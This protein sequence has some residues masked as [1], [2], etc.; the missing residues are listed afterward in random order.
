MELEDPF[1]A[2][3]A[4]ESVRWITTHRV[5]GELSVSRAIGDP[6]YKGVTPR[7]SRLIYLTGFTQQI[8]VFHVMNLVLFVYRQRHVG[9]HVGLPKRTLQKIY[10]RPRPCCPPHQGL[11]WWVANGSSLRGHTWYARMLLQEIDFQDDDEFFILACDGL[12]DVLDS[13]DAIDIVS[14]SLKAGVSAQV[15]LP[16]PSQCPKSFNL[17]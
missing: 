8:A 2:K 10:S 14:E 7:S 13:Q 5:N 15:P 1:I 12:W 16:T 9:V 3:K 17:A 6:D 4:R 11:T